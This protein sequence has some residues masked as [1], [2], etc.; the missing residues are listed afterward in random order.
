[1]SPPSTR[2][3]MLPI[4]APSPPLLLEGEGAWLFDCGELLDITPSQAKRVNE[5]TSNEALGER[6]GTACDPFEKGALMGLTSTTKSYLKDAS[7]PTLEKRKRCSDLSGC[8]VRSCGRM[9]AS[10][11]SLAPLLAIA[12]RL[13]GAGEVI[14]VGRRDRDLLAHVVDKTERPGVQRLAL[15][16]AIALARLPTIELVSE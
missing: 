11:G 4:S 2:L 16:Q 8:V 14:G 12:Q 7:T 6:V 9:P 1:M 10:R 3:F 13:E 15:D 5:S